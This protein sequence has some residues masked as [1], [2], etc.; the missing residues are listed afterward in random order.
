MQ[1]DT[2]KGKALDVIVKN[3]LT[4]LL[5]D[6]EVKNMGRNFIED[7]PECFYTEELTLLY[8]DSIIGD[9]SEYP[10]HALLL[11]PSKWDRGLF[12]QANCLL[13]T[14]SYQKL[15][16]EYLEKLSMFQGI[17]F[18]DK[19]YIARNDKVRL[20]TAYNFINRLVIEHF[21][22]GQDHNFPDIVE[23]SLDKAIE[24]FCFL[25]LA[26]HEQ[27]HFIYFLM[28]YNKFDIVN[29]NFPMCKKV[30]AA[31]FNHFIEVKKNLD[32]SNRLKR[33]RTSVY[34]TLEDIDLMTGQQFEHFI[35]KLFLNMGYT[36]EVT[37]S[38]GDQ[39]IDV[40][41]S[42]DGKKIGI[43]AKCY[44]S[45][46]GNSAIQEVVAGR[47]HY[48]LDRVMVVTNN[49]FT[50]AAKKLAQSNAVI[51]WDR[52][53]LKEKIIIIDEKK[54]DVRITWN[55]YGQYPVEQYF[56]PD[57]KTGLAMV[58]NEKGN[59]V[60]ETNYLDGKKNGLETSWYEN[61]Q[62]ESETNYI[63]G[64]RNNGIETSWYENGQKK[65]EINY[66]DGKKN[67]LET[68]WYENGQKKSEINY[69]DGKKNG[70]EKMW[71]EN[72]SRGIKME[73]ESKQTT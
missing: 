28:K 67:G 69:I 31:S 51:M 1:K 13:L 27:N 41:V 56:F 34:T 68:S 17:A 20:I 71:Y 48:K 25:N 2:D 70:L 40:I 57:E 65:S 15:G 47:A 64:Y 32:F 12:L 37:Q 24:R 45:S 3:I 38:S 42:K 19:N 63:D 23:L 14:E 35:A 60:Y 16:C 39:G 72:E 26:E 7:M 52:S 6:E 11:L 9:I 46:V 50:D 62:K 33:P 8:V 10:S 43:Q 5:A 54:N 61:G 49:F 18:Q 59:K 29:H 73:R 36:T 30:F 58:W 53:V 66:I 55:E 21:S 44:S 4:L 22:E